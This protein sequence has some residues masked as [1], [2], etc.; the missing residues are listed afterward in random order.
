VLDAYNANP[1]S[2]EL[3]IQSLE[4][5][6]QPK[7]MVILG[8]MF[9]LGEYSESEHIHIVELLKDSNFSQI[10]LVGAEF[11]KCASSVNCIHF[12]SASDVK[13]WITAHKP[14][15]TFIYVKGSRGMK[16]ESIFL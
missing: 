6:D 15:N 10:I 1:S 13:K 7:K 11:A 2:M 5:L 12:S 3:A 16:L 14:E 8:D 4:K 9:E